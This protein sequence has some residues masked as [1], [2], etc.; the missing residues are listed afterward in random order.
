MEVT[1]FLSS[2]SPII[3]DSVTVE[4][5]KELQSNLKKL[6][7]TQGKDN[8]AAVF[9]KICEYLYYQDGVKKEKGKLREDLDKFAQIMKE[10]TILGKLDIVN[11]LLQSHGLELKVIDESLNSKRTVDSSGKQFTKNLNQFAESSDFDKSELIGSDYKG[12][13]DILTQHYLKL[14]DILNEHREKIDF[15]KTQMQEK[16]N[17][18]KSFLNKTL[19]AKTIEELD[20][21]KFTKEIERMEQEA[22]HLDLILNIL[23]G[24]T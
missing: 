14:E 21:T 19:K 16:Y 23:Q 4:T 6:Y 3:D 5:V 20:L 7:A 24:K 9:S 18:S 22:T 13:L 17:L 2:L 12:F 8:K 1:Q 11:T 10:M 15:F